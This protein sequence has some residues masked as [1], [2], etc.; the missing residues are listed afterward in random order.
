MVST[1]YGRSEV[2]PFQV[3]FPAVLTGPFDSVTGYPWAQ[4]ILDVTVPGVETQPQPRTGNQGHTPDNN[5]GLQAG[6]RGWLEVD[7][8]AAGWIFTPTPTIPSCVPGSGSGSGSCACPGD[9]ADP[10]VLLWPLQNVGNSLYATGAQMAV[11][12]DVNGKLR[13]CPYNQTTTLVGCLT[14]CGSGISPGCVACGSCLPAS[15]LYVKNLTNTCGSCADALTIACNGVGVWTG[16]AT[17]LV[18]CPASATLRCSG[19]S[20]VIDVNQGGTNFVGLPVTVNSCSPFCAV[21]TVPATGGCAAQTYVI[22]DDPTFAACNGSGSGSGGGNSCCPSN[23]PPSSLLAAITNVTGNCTC[24]PT[25]FSLTG[26]FGGT[27]FSTSL[28]GICGNVNAN[29]V[30]LECVSG[31]W[32]L[33]WSNLGSGV[34]FTLVSAQC[35]PF[36][37]V[38]DVTVP[39]YNP[40]TE[41]CAGSF[42]V[43][44]S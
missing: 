2:R 8:Q 6:V 7:P 5:Q 4:L 9:G 23:P 29:Q 38:F 36:M 24:I 33:S 26:A 44:F 22:S 34:T 10:W 1:I 20:F 28:S 19:S 25:S 40:G 17:N 37:V 14:S 41:D 15:Q 21:F 11:Y 13:L 43:T 12:Q 39:S 32:H 16:Y 42:R 18:T 30:L 35:S 31:N 27:I 3:G